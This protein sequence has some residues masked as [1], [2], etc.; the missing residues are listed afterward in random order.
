MLIEVEGGRRAAGELHIQGAKNA[1]LP[2]LAATVLCKGTT[3]LE[4][5]PRIHDVTSMISIL[6]SM[7]AEVSWEEDSLRIDV[8]SLQRCQLTQEEVGQVRASILF[9]G[10]TLAR[11]GEAKICMPGGCSIGAR[12]ID[13]HLAAFEKLGARVTVQGEEI[14]CRCGEGDGSHQGCR[15]VELPFPSVGATE[16]V[17]LYAVLGERETEIHNAAMEPEIVELCRF[18]RGM[19]AQITGDGTGRI[20]IRGVE[21]LRETAYRLRPDRIVFFTYGAMIASA[22]GEAFLETEG[23]P[24]CEERKYLEMSGCQT[25]FC[26]KGILVRRKGGLQPIPLLRTMPYPGFPT[27]AQ[28]LFLALLSKA[29]GE[30]CIEETVFENRFRVV[31]QLRRM[32]ADIEVAGQRALIRGVTRLHGE[33]VRATDLRSG[34]ALLVAAVAADGV[35]TI[36]DSQLIL[37]GY[38]TPVENMRRLGLG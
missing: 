36:E 4:N 26:R 9:L 23:D 7:G 13:Y 28:S 31:S 12:P 21:E 18:L 29:G 25:E 35:T 6:K 27:D 34:A 15:V 1:V 37:R 30:S 22:G 8:S 3:V 19:G 16:N 17:I 24:M 32:G 11:Q 20:L 33:R 2:M 38:E 10:S 5:C 14:W